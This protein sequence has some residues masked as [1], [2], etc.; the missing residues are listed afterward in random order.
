MLATTAY[1]FVF[2]CGVMYVYRIRY[3][4]VEC[5]QSVLRI[6]LEDGRKERGAAAVLGFTIPTQPT[7]SL[8]RLF[9]PLAKRQPPTASG[10]FSLISGSRFFVPL[11]VFASCRLLVRKI[12]ATRHR[13]RLKRVSLCTWPNVCRRLAFFDRLPPPVYWRLHCTQ[14]TLQG[15]VLDGHALELKRSSKRL[16]PTT[17]ASSSTSSQGD[18]VKKSKLII[19]NIPFQ[20]GKHLH[21]HHTA[22]VFHDIGSTYVHIPLG[23]KSSGLNHPPV[24]CRGKD[25]ECEVMF[26]LRK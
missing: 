5:L 9:F 10:A 3:S 1:C 23:V 7:F 12:F 17:K 4:I 15:T 2:F 20:V 13:G 19:R 6:C 24:V 14:Q 16:T 25:D 18:D 11:F 8:S 22:L 21:L 26:V